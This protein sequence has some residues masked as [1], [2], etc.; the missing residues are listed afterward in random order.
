ME[1]VQTAAPI[2]LYRENLHTKHGFKEDDGEIYIWAYS[3]KEMQEY[4]KIV[5]SLSGDK[6]S[7]LLAKEAKIQNRIYASKFAGEIEKTKAE[8]N[9]LTEKYQKMLKK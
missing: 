8:L 3:S 6:K 7:R 4:F 2:T 1:A 5:Q 9:I